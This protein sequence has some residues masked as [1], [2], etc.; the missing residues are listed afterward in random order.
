MDSKYFYISHVQYE[1]SSNNRQPEI[2]KWNK[3]HYVEIFENVEWRPYIS[4]SIVKYKSD[5]FSKPKSDKYQS[6]KPII[7]DLFDDYY[8]HALRNIYSTKL[9][10][11]EF[12]LIENSKD[13]FQLE[14]YSEDEKDKRNVSID[15]R[16]SIED[17]WL[18]VDSNHGHKSRPNARKNGK[19]IKQEDFLL[20]LNLT[21]R[22]LSDH[23]S[24][25]V[26]LDNYIKDFL[27]LVSG[28]KKIESFDLSADKAFKS[29]LEALEKR[30]AKIEKRL[31]E[32]DQDTQEDRIKLRGE[33]EGLNYAIKTVHINK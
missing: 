2:V 8:N 16:N 23:N 30:K 3:A 15:F 26:Y 5:S 28:D 32:N 33:L 25:E 22:F 6:V 1:Y 27:K 29:I 14:Y 17:L 4:L 21:L 31:I 20:F 7:E 18:M 10:E 24:Y 11:S 13:W 12:Y 19:P 9:C